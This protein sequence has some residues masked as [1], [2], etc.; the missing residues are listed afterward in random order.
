MNKAWTDYYHNLSGIQ[1]H[2]ESHLIVRN[3]QIY[4]GC[5]YLFGEFW[6]F[7]QFWRF[8]QFLRFLTNAHSFFGEENHLYFYLRL[9]C[10]SVMSVTLRKKHNFPNYRDIRKNKFS[11][12]LTC[13]SGAKLGAISF[14]LLDSRHCDW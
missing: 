9:T 1:G 11:L 5:F 13:F 6:N 7:D 12:T 4:L 8:C 14:V 2:T 3:K 10:D